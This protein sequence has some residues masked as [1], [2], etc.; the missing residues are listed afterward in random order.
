V[1]DYELIAQ[2]VSSL[3]PRIQELE[4][5]L[6]VLEEQI[7]DVQKVNAR[8]EAAALTTARSLQQIATHWDAVYKAMRR[9]E[10]AEGEGDDDLRDGD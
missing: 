8:L 10:I 6:D 3:G 7:A 5:R 9:E 2:E 1:Q 4:E